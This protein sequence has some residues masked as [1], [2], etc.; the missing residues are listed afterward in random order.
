MTKKKTNFHPFSSQRSNHDYQKH[1]Y[2]YYDNHQE[3]FN[4]SD[5]DNDSEN[6]KKYQ[7]HWTNHG[8]QKNRST[9]ETTINHNNDKKDFEV[10]NKRIQ[11]D[12]DDGSGDAICFATSIIHGIDETK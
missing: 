12:V 3:Y 1:N 6:P 4:H 7:Q 9:L 5:D 11:I 10:E 2:Y 8:C